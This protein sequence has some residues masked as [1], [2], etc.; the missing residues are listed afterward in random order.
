MSIQNLINSIQIALL[1][2][3]PSKIAVHTQAERVIG[4]R[5]VTRAGRNGGDIEFLVLPPHL[6][7][8]VESGAF[9]GEDAE[10]VEAPAR[11]NPQGIQVVFVERGEG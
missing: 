6:H 4:E 1:R 2:D 3:G 8:R 7:D 9:L 11:D 10:A 5:A